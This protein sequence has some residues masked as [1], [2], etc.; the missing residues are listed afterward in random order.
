MSDVGFMTPGGAC[1]GC[2]ATCRD[3]KQIACTELMKDTYL[4]HISIDKL[5][6]NA[7]S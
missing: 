3:I 5:D 4:M 6:V 2:Q 7:V 1:G